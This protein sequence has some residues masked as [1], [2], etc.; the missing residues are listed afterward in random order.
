MINYSGG[1]IP[2]GLGVPRAGINQRDD[3]EPADFS[4]L[5]S[6]FAEQRL[7]GL[8]AGAR[9]A[10]RYRY[11]KIRNAPWEHLVVK[12]ARDVSIYYY[13]NMREYDAN[14]Y[15]RELCEKADRLPLSLSA[16]DEEVISFAERQA[17]ISKGQA[18]DGFTLDKRL[19]YAGKM[20]ININKIKFKTDEG[21]SLRLMCSKFWRRQVRK[22][23]A[24]E[25]ESINRNELGIVSKFRQPYISDDSLNSRR[26]QKRR[27]R[28]ILECIEVINEL[29]QRFTLLDLMERSVANPAIRR[30]ELMTR[31]AGFEHI[32]VECGHAG[33]FLTL[34]CPSSYHAR[35]V[36]G[37][38]NP[39][40]KGFGPDEGAKY[41]SRVWAR[42]LTEL[43]RNDIK[44]Y[45]FRVAEPHHD[46]TP[47][48]HGL[49]FMQKDQISKFR[50][51]VA[52]HAV[53]EDK[54]ELRLHYC[55]TAKEAK[56]KARHKQ[57]KL[58]STAGA[59]VPPLS[60]IL[61]NIKI[62]SSFWSKPPRGAFEQ[63]KARV[64]FKSIDWRRGSAAGYI[65]K[66]IAK[67]I[68]GQNVHG[69]VI[70][71]D[72]EVD[73]RLSASDSAERV[74]A[75]ASKWGIRQFQQI[76]GAPVTV[77][78]ELRR[79]NYV[80]E[81]AEDVLLRASIAAD[82]GDWSKFIEVMGGY[83][84][85]RKDMPLKLHK[86]PTNDLNLYQEPC[87]KVLR[88]VV[89]VNTGELAITRTTV[90]QLVGGGA[91]GGRAA[92]WT[93]V[94][95][96][97]KNSFE[98][99]QKPIV[100]SLEGVLLLGDELALF[101]INEHV[102]DIK[103]YEY[104]SQSHESAEELQAASLIKV[105]L[106]DIRRVTRDPSRGLEVIKAVKDGLSPLVF[107]DMPKGE[108]SRLKY[109]KPLT[110]DQQAVRAKKFLAEQQIQFDMAAEMDDGLLLI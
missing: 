87:D 9:R 48:W 32:A 61:Q 52:K 89:D 67:N 18:I 63:V 76:G 94:N 28:R 33:E 73:G 69:E 103:D 77:W 8:P 11:L 68:D 22:C 86:D 19:S 23:L 38:R 6:A 96:S 2:D 43:A 81:G 104:L 59:V 54:E 71:V 7:A 88:G 24:R 13:M 29:G 35:R 14:A 50:Q 56:E 37:R 98:N 41:L 10:A 26:E 106:N 100:E 53:R 51:I 102:F 91:L 58:K 40:F 17:N 39:K 93:G 12:G 57:E 97:T 62:E 65:A 64:D 15:L 108:S 44:I 36:S 110:L 4:S 105:L 95:N 60:E 70:G 72:Y 84:K 25:I 3:V 92:A 46:G 79:F 55:L 83:A 85:S 75:W 16:T 5:P 20:G 30:A 82:L 78:R 107:E 42:I 21:L 49:F 34:T 74:D 27:N 109:R 101:D 47:H 90:W 66:Y 31:I 80:A 99:P 1:G 45:G